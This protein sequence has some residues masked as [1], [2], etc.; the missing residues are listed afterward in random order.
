M[1]TFFFEGKRD[2]ILNFLLV[3]NMG[4]NGGGVWCGE[5]GGEGLAIVLDVQSLFAPWADIILSQ[6]LTYYLQ[7]IFLLTLTSDNTQCNILLHCLWA[8]SNNRTRNQCGRDVTW[9]RFLFFICLVTCL[10]QLLFH[11]LF[12]FSRCPNK[13][14]WLQNEH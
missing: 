1:A 6:T 9:F 11:S 13:T 10:V 5:G 2:K 7:E 3:K 4:K 8:K 12:T 14:G